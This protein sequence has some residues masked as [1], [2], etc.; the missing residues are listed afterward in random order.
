MASDSGD[1]AAAL[2][3]RVAQLEE[4]VAE[5]QAT[6]EPSSQPTA[7]RRGLLSAAAGVAGLGALGIYSSYPASA[8]AVGQVGTASNP[9]DVEAW[10]LN[11]Q[12]QLAG[13]LDAGGNS[14]ANVASAEVKQQIVGPWT[15]LHAAVDWE[16]PHHSNGTVTVAVPGD[17][18][19]I[20][21]AMR[22]VPER[23]EGDYTIKVDST[24]TWNE[25]VVMPPT[26][27]HGPRNTTEWS[28]GKVILRP[29]DFNDGPVSV[30]SVAAFVGTSVTLS[31]I[32]P[33]E[34][35]PADEN[36]GIQIFGQGGGTAYLTNMHFNGSTSP[37]NGIMCY[38]GSAKLESTGGLVYD[39]GTDNL[40][41]FAE[42]KFGGTV[43]STLSG[44][45]LIGSVTGTMFRAISGSIYGR[46]NVNATAGTAFAR[47]GRG[48]F[49][50][51]TGYILS[52]PRGVNPWGV[53]YF[54][55]EMNAGSD[56]AAPDEGVRLYF[57]SDLSPKELRAINEYN[58]VT[59]IATF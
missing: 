44:G 42:T 3:E 28:P 52:G 58:T 49:F 51:Q 33:L 20:M 14:L 6:S 7:S 21:D 4:T 17:E 29:K 37:T 26:I 41:N 36:F 18:P 25:D 54:D 8:Q 45:D 43:Y 48:F 55:I 40:N 34:D 9:I 12:D 47:P 15:S 2:R 19:T 56:P 27:G 32:Q 5:Q 13:D 16:R 38:G 50:D 23:L 39:L 53:D 11:V 57:R 22:K 59:T 46:S 35:T 30:K 10:S 24:S 31:H 1:D